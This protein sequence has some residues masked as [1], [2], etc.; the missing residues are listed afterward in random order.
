MSDAFTRFKF[1]MDSVSHKQILSEIYSILE[2]TKIDIEIID[3]FH[4]SVS[5]NE[6]WWSRTKLLL[7]TSVTLRKVLNNIY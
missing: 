2:T 5:I 7:N 3:H 4:P 6:F 1:K